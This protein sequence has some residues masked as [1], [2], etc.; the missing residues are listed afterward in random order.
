MKITQ[1]VIHGMIF[2]PECSMREWRRKES[3]SQRLKVSG[4]TKAKRQEDIKCA[5]LNR[6][7]L[8]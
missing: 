7:C 5:D 6:D 3:E 2:P 4:N 1:Q 8:S